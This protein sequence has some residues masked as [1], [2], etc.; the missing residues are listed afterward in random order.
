MKKQYKI[1]W[2]PLPVVRSSKDKAVATNKIR[3]TR[4]TSPSMPMELHRRQR[5]TTAPFATGLQE[6]QYKMDKL[7]PS[8]TPKRLPRQPTT[9]SSPSTL[10]RPAKRN[11]A[12]TPNNEWESPPVGRPKW[13]ASPIATLCTTPTA[14]P[15]D[16]L[17]PS[18][19]VNTSS[20]KTPKQR[21]KLRL[22]FG[23]SPITLPFPE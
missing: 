1:L 5:A 17:T 23:L 22:S 16:A 19:L 13:S 7:L 10:P 20:K 14:L 15:F 21:S 2:T 9:S 3:K 11:S 18:P 8:V 4:T 6:S 12:M